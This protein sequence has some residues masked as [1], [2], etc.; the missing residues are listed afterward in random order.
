MTAPVFPT[1]PTPYD[2]EG[3]EA[4]EKVCERAN[5]DELLLHELGRLLGEMVQAL[6]VESRLRGR[7]E[8]QPPHRRALLVAVQHHGAAGVVALVRDWVTTKP[9]RE[10]MEAALKSYLAGERKELAREGRR[11]S[12]RCTTDGGSR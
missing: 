12:G 6:D 5:A 7:D 9:T 8:W 11:E 4:A 2:A 3:R 1:S 10:Q